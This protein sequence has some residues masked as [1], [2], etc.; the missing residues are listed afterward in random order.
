VDRLRTIGGFAKAAGVATSTIRYYERAG[1]LRPS[2]RTLSNY[3][4]Y[5]NEDLHRLRFVRGA[6]ATGFT[7]DDIREL[8]RPA[9]CHRVQGLIEARLKE[10]AARVR[11]LRRFE[12][13]LRD[14]LALCRAHAA[15]GRCKVVDTLSSQAR[16][17]WRSHDAP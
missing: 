15:T 12:K 14:S 6:Q 16:R 17:S 5:T 2:G 4:F 8:L 7:L 9:A 10:V 3:R 11:E 1:L 13:V